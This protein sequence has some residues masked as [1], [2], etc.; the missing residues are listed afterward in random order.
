MPIGRI[1]ATGCVE[2]SP[3]PAAP[4]NFGL[5]SQRDEILY[6]CERPGAATKN[7]AEGATPPEE[8]QL[9]VD[10]MKSQSVRRVLTLL[11]DKELSWYGTP[12]FEIY[13]REGFI[14]THAPFGAPESK[15]SAMA[16]VRA[17]K[18]AGEVIVAHCTHGMGRSGCVAAAWLVEEYGLSLIE[19]TQEVMEQADTQSTQRMGDVPR[20][21]KFLGAEPTAE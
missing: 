3:D 21:A 17:A 9:W 16:A 6:T 5:A 18:E 14:Y 8:I 7:D 15:D 13:E 19:A 20:L 4:F 12:L 11:E 1:T 10:F 2:T